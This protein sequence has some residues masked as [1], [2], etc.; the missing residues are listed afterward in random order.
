MQKNNP[1]R[2]LHLLQFFLFFVNHNEDPVN[3]PMKRLLCIVAVLLSI[4]MS[5]EAA[6]GNTIYGRVIDVNTHSGVAGAMVGIEGTYLWATAD[7]KGEFVLRGVQNGDYTLQATCLGY[8]PY[9]LEISVRKDM[10]GV[11][12]QMTQQTLAIDEVVVTAQT[13]SSVPNTTYTIGSDALQHM[14]VSNVA[15]VAA[16]LPGGKTLNPDLTRT[17]AQDNAF[18]IRGGGSREGNASFGTAVEVDGVRLSNN[19]SFN[20]ES[21]SSNITGVDT[22]NI[23][24]S[25]IES[26]EIVTGVP[27]AEYGDLNSGMVKINTRKGYSPWKIELAVNPRTYQASFSKGFDLGNDNG[28]LNVSGEWTRATSNLVSPYTSY[29]RRGFS[30]GYLKTFRRVLKFDVGFTGNIGGMN[31]KDDPDAYKGEY[32]KVRD[33]VFR[34][35]TS[36]VWLLNRKWITNLKLEASVNFNDNLSHAH[37]LVSNSNLQPAVHSEAEGYYLADLLPYTFYPDRI[38]DSKELDFAASLKYDWNRRWGKVRS[39]LKA[40]VQWKANGNAGQGEYYLDPS[41][42]PNGYRPRPYTDYPFMH[43]LSAYVEENFVFPI[44][45][46]SFELTAGLRF[47]NIT[48]RD[49]DY[50]NLNTFSPRLNARWR[51]TDNISLRGSW[52]I[53]YKLPSYYVLYPKQEYRDTQTLGFNDASGKPWYVYYTQ[54]YAMRHNADLKWQRNENAEVGVDMAFGGFRISLAAFSNLTKLPYKYSTAYDPVSYLMLEKPNSY[55]MPANPQVRVDSQTGMVYVRADDSEQWTPMDVKVV[56]QSFVQSKYSDNGTDV[57]RRGVELIVD[58]PQINPIRTHFRFDAVYNYTKYLD[59][60]LSWYY[61]S[62]KSHTSLPNRAYEYA[63]IYANGGG[64]STINGKTTNTIDANLTAITHIPRA[65]IVISCKLEMTLL[66]RFRNL[67]EYNGQEYAFTVGEDGNSPTGG[68]IYDGDSYAAIRPVS[69]VDLDGNIHPFTD[70][71]AADTRFNN[72]ILRTGNAYTFAADGYDPYF[73]ANLSI[74]KEIGDHVS[75][76]FNANNFTN[77]R[78]YVKSY[79]NGVYAIFTPAFYYGLTCRIKF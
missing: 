51:F 54:P 23:S 78:R 38:V 33:N 61:A 71:E 67:S 56:N 20:T 74:T 26:V 75:L 24:V 43:N 8:V 64:T 31:S 63:G 28:A 1:S 11:V 2:V 73:S 29:T 30:A 13:V 77:S 17:N 60:S 4:N 50:D 66:R 5:A 52:G 12:I 14:Q 47:E 65:R 40:G 72:L 36:L 3:L 79:A 42:A 10:D 76:T 57:I 22:R 45:R 34:A 18:M 69:Y 15:D 62:G 58:F 32:T 49:A 9:S 44:G 25:N 35:N 39:S 21:T 19:A 55:T 53:A 41:L 46:T 16:L 59:N 27:S 70:A 68:S 37:T 48:I 7:N 6:G